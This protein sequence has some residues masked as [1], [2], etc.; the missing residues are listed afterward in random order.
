MSN[1]KFIGI[2]DELKGKFKALLAEFNVIPQPVTPTPTPTMT[3]PE[4]V[5]KFGEVKTKDGAIIKWDGDAPYAV[6]TVLM[7]I[8]PANPEGFL[9]AP[10]GEVVLEDGTTL[11]IEGGAIKE[12]KPAAPAAPEVPAAPD[13]SKQF[14]EVTEAFAAFKKEKEDSEKALKDEIA[15]LT[16]SVKQMFSLLGE[17]METPTANPEEQPKNVDFSKMTKKEKLFF[18]M[19]GKHLK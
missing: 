11:V 18:D 17:A 9:P 6:G 7:V 19:T 2:T 8:D 1:T 4:P 14:A 12:I 15:K 16:N 13:M 3:T 5:K 10:D